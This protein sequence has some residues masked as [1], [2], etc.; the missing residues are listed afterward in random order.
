MCLCCVVDGTGLFGEANGILRCVC[1][2]LL[3]ELVCLGLEMG[4]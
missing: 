1:V 2:V 4:F 3:M